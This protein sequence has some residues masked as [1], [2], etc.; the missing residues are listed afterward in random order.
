[1][2]R[3]PGLAAE[4]KPKPVALWRHIRRALWHQR[5]SQ[6]RVC[7]PPRDDVIA[8]IVG[9]THCNL[10]TS[11]YHIQPSLWLVFT[12]D[13][14]GALGPTTS[15][16]KSSRVPAKWMDAIS[17]MAVMSRQ[18]FSQY[19]LHWRHNGRDGFSN[20][21]PRDCLLNRLFRRR[22]NKTSKLRVIVLFAGNSP[23]THT[24]GQLRGKCFHSMTSSWA[25]C[26]WEITCGFPMK[27]PMMWRLDDI[28]LLA[29]TICYVH[30]RVAGD[31]RHQNFLVTSL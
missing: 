29:C 18:L 21:L 17:C 12:L 13:A 7:H 2:N 5:S 23:V 20:R 11:I 31:M 3:G 16:Q 6:L 14:I 24:N 28:F 8:G 15:I 9:V 27:K 22:S 1:M 10:P 30:S 25:H 19:S 26:V 4:H